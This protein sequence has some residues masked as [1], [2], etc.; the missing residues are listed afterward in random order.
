MVTKTIEGSLAVAQVVRNCSPDV[1]ACYPITSSTHIAEDLNKMYTDG[2]LRS[3]IAVEAEFSAISALV[4]GSAAGGRTFST[5]SSQGLAL[6]HEVLFTAAGMRLPIVMCIANRT[7][8]APLGIWCD[9]QDSISQRDTGWIQLYCES[10]QEA[11]DTIPQ[12][13]KI[14]E[15]NMLPAMVCIDGFYLTHAVE[16]IDVPEKEKIEKFLPPFN[17]PFKLD[18]KNP[19]SFGEYA[20]PEDYQPFREDISKDVDKT[21]EDIKKANDEWKNITGRGYGNGLW[22]EYKCDDADYILIAMSSVVGNAKVA[23]DEM[24]KD[25]KSVGVLRIKSFR[26]FPYEI[27]DALKGKKGV[28]VFDRAV[29]LGGVAPLY[30]E[31]LVSLFASEEKRPVL[32]SFIGGLGGRDVTVSHVKDMFEK[33][34]EEKEV[35]M[36]IY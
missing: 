4:G 30:G 36:F 15:K 5:T 16:Q 7:L 1:V 3:F 31:V 22:E 24:R 19:L 17:P 12:A 27:E 9:H 14:A 28:G 35:K 11:A 23:V 33:I 20:L 34:M 25:G 29:S 21:R 32:S 6:M 26:P 8:S 2:E 18:P 10:N 13:Y